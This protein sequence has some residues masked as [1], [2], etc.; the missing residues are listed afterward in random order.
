MSVEFSI[1]SSINGVKYFTLDPPTPI[2]KLGEYYV[3]LSIG[4]LS[5]TPAGDYPTSFALK[6]IK[7]H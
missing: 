6:I 1:D 2:V 5:G 7:D 4:C 3:D